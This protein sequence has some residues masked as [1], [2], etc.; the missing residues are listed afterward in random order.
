MAQKNLDSIFTKRLVFCF[1]FIMFLFLISAQVIS[2]Q[3]STGEE[4]TSGTI[5]GAKKTGTETTTT[6]N[7]PSSTKSTGEQETSGNIFG[8]LFG[9][10]EKTWWKKTKEFLGFKEKAWYEKLWG[11]VTSG[12]RTIPEIISILIITGVLYGLG[13][14]WKRAERY[15]KNPIGWLI[16]LTLLIIF[17]PRLE[18][19]SWFGLAAILK[20]LSLFI[21]LPFKILYETSVIREIAQI[22]WMLF[23]IDI[24]S[25]IGKYLKG[26][27]DRIKEAKKDDAF[28]DGV[29]TIFVVGK[30]REEAMN[31][32]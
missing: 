14:F 17:A 30:S 24:G 23:I 9:K 32:S 29:R 2:A 22:L 27:P 8:N 28:M 5:F 15:N 4:E 25:K 7:N 1:I 6:N 11:N 19:T 20:I 31:P 12:A 13:F 21:V 18:W 26:L 10:E 16:C 3:T